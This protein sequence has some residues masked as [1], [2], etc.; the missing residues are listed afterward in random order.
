MIACAILLYNWWYSRCAYTNITTNM[1]GL[2]PICD[3]AD[4]QF[5]LHYN[6]MRPPP[7]KWTITD[8]NIVMGFM[9]TYIALEISNIL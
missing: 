2:Y 4:R 8:Q 6:L 7:H 9:T 1:L 5:Q 3:V